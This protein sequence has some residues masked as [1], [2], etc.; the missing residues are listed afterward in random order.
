V[1]LDLYTVILDLPTPALRARIEARV[2]VM[3]AAGFLDEVRALRAAGFGPARALQAL[4]Y[5]Q[6]GQH[7]DGACTLAEAIAE[8]KSATFSYA[9]R[10]RT[11]FRKEPATLRAETAPEPDTLADVIRAWACAPDPI[12]AG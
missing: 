1:P 7:L 2:E 9:R 12:Q 11:W 5:R 10:Q 3:M 8:T 4:G 6:L